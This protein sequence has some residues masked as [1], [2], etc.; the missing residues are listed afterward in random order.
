MARCEQATLRR[1]RRKGRD[2]RFDPI[3]AASWARL[4][5]LHRK[6]PSGTL[7]QLR[8]TPSSSSIRRSRSRCEGAFAKEMLDVDFVRGG[9]TGDASVPAPELPARVPIA[10]YP[11]SNAR[12]NWRLKQCC[13]PRSKIVLGLG[14]GVIRDHE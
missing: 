4:A 2:D 7:L 12:I 6:P 3:C 9:D 10:E 11:L 5:E 8:P 13:G 14:D 1:P